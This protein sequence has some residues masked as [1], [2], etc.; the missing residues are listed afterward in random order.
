M[1]LATNKKI[2]SKDDVIRVARIYFSRWKIEEYFRCIRCDMEMK[3]KYDVKVEGAAY[4]LK[5]TKPGIFKGDLG[6]IHC[7]VCPKCGYIELYLKEIA[8]SLRTR[9]FIM[10]LF[11]FLFL[12]LL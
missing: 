5:I 12:A 11:N 4:A 2:K 8:V 7:A 1:M 10:L 3:E 6:K 9:F